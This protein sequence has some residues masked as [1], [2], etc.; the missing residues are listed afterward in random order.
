MTTKNLLRGRAGDSLLDS[1]GRER[2]PIGKQVVDRA[3]KS[4]G[5]LRPLAEAI[6]IRPGQSADKGWASI[7]ELFGDFKTANGLTLPSSYSLE[8]T[9]ELQNGTTNVYRWDASGKLDEVDVCVMRCGG[10]NEIFGGVKSLRNRG[11]L[12]GTLSTQ[13]PGQGVPFH[14]DTTAHSWSRK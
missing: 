10:A 5:E 13:V 11:S 9:Q 12:F 2:Q 4:I 14:E 3:V 8:F 6:G 7:E 1:Y